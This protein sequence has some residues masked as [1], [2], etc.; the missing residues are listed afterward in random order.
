MINKTERG[1]AAM[2]F[3]ALVAAPC[4]GADQAAGFDRKE[5]IRLAQDY[6]AVE[7]M[8]RDDFPML[9][10][11]PSWGEIQKAAKDSEAESGGCVMDQKTYEESLKR[12][13]ADANDLKQ[14]F[15]EFSQWLSAN[16]VS[17]VDQ[18]CRQGYPMRTVLVPFCVERSLQGGLNRWDE[19][20]DFASTFWVALALPKQPRSFQEQ[21]PVIFHEWGHYVFHRMMEESLGHPVSADEAATWLNPLD[22]GFADFVSYAFLGAPA[23]IEPPMRTPLSS[24]IADRRLVLEGKYPYFKSED[25]SAGEPFRDVLIRVS[26]VYGTPVALQIAHEIAAE[27]LSVQRK[28]TGSP[29]KAANAA[30]LAVFQRRAIPTAAL[31]Q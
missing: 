5:R 6:P 11:V 9:I 28:S 10:L 13:L 24:S 4:K 29:E 8:V 20:L 26:V 16:G 22:E 12:Q 2:L 3:L 1:L 14:K 25:H 21:F 23:H 19:S 18:A 15:A 30:V 7:Y 27:I 31:L 17:Y